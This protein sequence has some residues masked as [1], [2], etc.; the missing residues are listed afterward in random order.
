[1]LD[2]FSLTRRHL[3]HV[4]VPVCVLVA[5]AV[6]FHLRPARAMI[7]TWD[8][9]GIT[10][11]WS[12]A[13]NWMPDAVP[14]PGDSV[15]FDGTSSKNSTIDGMWFFGSVGTLTISSGYSGV[16]SQISFL[17][18]SN[19]SQA[20][21]TFMA[22]FGG[23]LINSMFQLS[24]G[25]YMA[26]SGTNQF[27][28]DVIITGG[29]FEGGDGSHEYNGPLTVDS[30]AWSKMNGDVTFADTV[31][32]NGGSYTGTVG[33]TTF[34]SD[35][36]VSDSASAVFNGTATFDGSTAQL[37][38]TSTPSFFNM[39]VSKSAGALTF[40]NNVD[41]D[42]TLSVTSGT[43]N[44]NGKTISVGDTVTVSGSGIY[45]AS[46]ATNTFDGGLTV[47]GGTFTG[48]SGAVDVNGSVTHSSGTF[49]AP[50]GTF[51]VSGGWTQ[52]SGTF[53]PGS[54]LVT[55]DGV[56]QA[57]SH[58]GSFN[59][60][61]FAGTN[62]KTL[63]SA[64]VVDGNLIISSTLA[65]AG[66]AITLAGNWTNNGT[67]IP[68]AGTVTLNGGSQS[69][70]GSA[71][72]NHL[73]KTSAAGPTLTFEAGSTQTVN[74]TLTLQGDAAADMLIRSSVEDT[75]F[76]LTLA[77]V[78]MGRYLDVQDSVATKNVSCLTGCNDSENNTLW[79]F[80]VASS[81][82]VRTPVTSTPSPE[83]SA[84]RF[85]TNTQTLVPGELYELAWETDGRVDL[86]NLAWSA[87]GGETWTDILR[88]VP[89]DPTVYFW[90][91]PAMEASSVLVRVE[92][93]DMAIVY[94]S[95][96]R[97][98][99]NGSVDGSV[100]AGEQTE[101]V[102]E[103]PE[104]PA[105]VGILVRTADRP[106]IFFLPGD[107][108]RRSFLDAQTFFTYEADFSHVRFMD[109][110]TLET[111]PLGAPMLPKPG[112]K[113]VKIVEDPKVYVVEENPD[114]V[115]RFLIRHIPNEETA[116]RFFGALWNTNVLDVPVILFKQFVL[117]YPL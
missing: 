68:G 56:A 15:T 76:T 54:N 53:T 65:A 97:E 96:T 28:G 73:I 23:I 110:A 34:S 4:A 105:L 17:S 36:T 83:T 3:L 62:T 98:I 74:G 35:I 70:L 107:G 19:F 49:T 66:N 52:S 115:T 86:V 39:V 63:G 67:F 94:A 37:V 25:T 27:F 30:G 45:L 109:A 91:V 40:S 48:S 7:Y 84:I 111:L 92:A 81:N 47:S 102:A 5:F 22:G 82:Q 38:D 29:A 95:D 77:N 58:A 14:S 60:V 90:S 2:G 24:G 10:N 43:L 21:G 72:F 87:D 50:S 78:A 104:A 55:F 116:M 32:I 99:S 89:V 44:L 93:T 117:G 13:N 80:A 103:I 9:G 113:L 106:D 31:T 114:D 59:N 6:L 1:M 8:G 71:T 33:N 11:N 85:K 64:L 88:G 61:T 51:T 69:V 16:I 26:G 46:T 112:A 20:D 100:P 18:V 79:Q 101:P 57:I 12:E 75:T 41:V 42:G 108:T